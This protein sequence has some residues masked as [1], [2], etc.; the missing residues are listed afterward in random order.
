MR[1]FDEQLL[2]LK[3]VT[4]VTADQDVAALLGMTKAA[5]SDRKKRDAFPEDKVRALATRHP[6]LHLDIEFVLT[7]SSDVQRELNKRLA[8]LKSVTQKVV[9]MKIPEPYGST[10]QELLFFIE[11]HDVDGV[12]KALKGLSHQLAAGEV[13]PV[14]A[15]EETIQRKRPR[16]GRTKK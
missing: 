6:E 14:A 13:K 10:V 8:A 15:P 1:K 5:F 4:G 9:E 12:V 7:G 16:T 2:R 3:Q 11:L